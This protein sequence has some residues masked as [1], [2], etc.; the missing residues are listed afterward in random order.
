MRIRI[1]LITLLQVWIRLFTLM[2]I[3]IR[4][5]IFCFVRIRILLFTLM[6][7]RILLLIRVMQNL[8]TLTYRPSI[9]LHFEPVQLPNFD[10]DADPDPLLILMRIR[11]RLFTLMWDPQHCSMISF[12]VEFSR[13]HTGFVHCAF[14]PYD[15]RGGCVC[16]V[17]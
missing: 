5:R 1:R 4:M 11:I 17:G 9:R 6:R 3:R 7:I 15:I 16:G 12:S 2:R 14:V 10:F 13:G 8:R